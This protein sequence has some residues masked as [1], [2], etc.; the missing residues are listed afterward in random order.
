[1]EIAAADHDDDLGWVE[2]AETVQEPATETT[3]SEDELLSAVEGYYL[4]FISFISLR[5]R[6]YTK[7][8]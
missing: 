2:D 8:M 4:G 3:S 6:V 1:M 5:E 7:G